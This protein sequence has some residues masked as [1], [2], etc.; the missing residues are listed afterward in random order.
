MDPG[1]SKHTL[2]SDA[3]GDSPTGKKQRLEDSVPGEHQGECVIESLYTS[4]DYYAVQDRVSSA[5]T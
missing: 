2:Q 4:A 5:S 3:S 1:A